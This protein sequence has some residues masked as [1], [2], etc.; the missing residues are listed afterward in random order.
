[1]IHRRPA[2]AAQ[3]SLLAQTSDVT[4]PVLGKQRLAGWTRLSRGLYVPTATRTSSRDL[5]AWSLLLPASAAF[6]HLTA[7]R[8]F[9]W[10]LPEQVPQP[11]FVA[12]REDATIP[13][14]PDLLISRH[15]RPLP[16]HRGRRPSARHTGGDASGGGPA[17]APRRPD[18]ANRHPAAGSAQRIGLGVGDA[19]LAPR[20]PT[21][22]SSRSTR[23]STSGV[24]SSPGPTCGSGEPAGYTNTTAVGIARSRSTSPTSTGTAAWSRTTG[25]DAASPHGPCSG[26]AARL[27]PRPTAGWLARGTRPACNAGT[28]WSPNPC[29]GPAVAPSSAGPGGGP[30]PS[31]KCWAGTRVRAAILSRANSYFG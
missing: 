10:W 30:S 21:S 29:S 24:S 17:T 3:L 11:I 26:T 20:R 18:A 13:V 7:A 5:A 14:R 6:T 2:A 19:G 15:P 8:Q 9:G 27:S 12:A 25:N 31:T 22:T 16:G 23:S 1:M 28:P 4:T